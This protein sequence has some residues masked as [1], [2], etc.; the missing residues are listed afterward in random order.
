MKSLTRE[1]FW[2]PGMDGEIGSIARSSC[3]CQENGKNLQKVPIHPWQLPE[4][5]WE[6]LHIGLEGLYFG[7]MWLVVEDAVSKWPEIIKLRTA[8]S[9][10]VA[11]NLMKIFAVQGLPEKLVSDN[12]LQF[13][14]VEFKEF[15]RYR[16]ISN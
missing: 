7:F 5:P 16:G 9:A 10:T 8:T 4:K 15:G 12:A 14:S 2:C 3:E 1:H 6:R 13:T 11:K